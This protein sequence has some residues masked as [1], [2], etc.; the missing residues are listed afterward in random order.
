MNK[1]NEHSEKLL[2]QYLNNSVSD[3]EKIKFFILSWPSGIWKSETVVQMSKKI[4]WNYFYNDFLHIKDF[5]KKLWKEHEL[6]VEYN[7]DNVT[8]KELLDTYNYTDLGTREINDRLGISPAG[9]KKIVLIEN[10]ERMNRS[11]VNAFLKTCEEPLANRIILATTSNKSRLLDTIISRAIIIPFFEYSYEELE[12]YC[13]EKWYFAWDKDL[14]SFVCMMSMWKIW[15]VDLFHEKIS[16]NEELKDQFKNIISIL[17]NGNLWV[18]YQLLLSIANNWFIEPVLDWLVSYYILHDNL[19]GAQNWLNVR[20][21]IWTN[22]K[23]DH[24]L[25]SAIISGK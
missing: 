21:N 4:L 24:L 2:E 5:S 22:V 9:T 23:I 1:A 19:A 3:W 20:K 18:K 10:I 6:K 7:S 25:F 14:K 8:S 17:E 13:D 16:E 11:A 12:N 15:N